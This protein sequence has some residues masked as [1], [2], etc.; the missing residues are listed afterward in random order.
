MNDKIK[1]TY[2]L[3]DQKGNKYECELP[4]FDDEKNFENLSEDEKNNCFSAILP[5]E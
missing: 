3:Q 4:D 5:W 1:N 2:W